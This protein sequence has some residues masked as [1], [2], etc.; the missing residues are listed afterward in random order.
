MSLPSEPATSVFLC[1]D[2]NFSGKEDGE[3]GALQ[4]WR[5]Q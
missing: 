1:G 3:S 2:T 5:R 4:D